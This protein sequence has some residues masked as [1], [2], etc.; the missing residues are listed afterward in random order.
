VNDRN[1]HEIDHLTIKFW[2]GTIAVLLPWLVRLAAGHTLPSVSGSY[3]AGDWPRNI[4]VGA[5]ISIAALISAYNGYRRLDLVMAKV[6]AV[7]AVGTSLF[8]SDP[9]KIIWPRCHAALHYVSGGVLFVILTYFCITFFRRARVKAAR[10]AKR[11]MGVYVLCAVGIVGAIAVLLVDIIF[12]MILHSDWLDTHVPWL[13]F[14]AETLALTAFGVSW[15]TASH[16]LPYL[17]APEE[18]Y[19]VDVLHR[20]QMR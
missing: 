12:N 19:H 15:L 2:V 20:R 17:N 5:L 18:R 16:V 11:R 13:F 10:E 3:W 8:P 1:F 4:F 7:A 6:A 9:T 14:Y